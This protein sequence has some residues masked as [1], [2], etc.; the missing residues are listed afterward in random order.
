MCSIP[1]NCSVSPG[2]SNGNMGCPGLMATG[3]N[4]TNS[5]P[6]GINLD[7]EMVKADNLGTTFSQN[8]WASA[9][10]EGCLGC[11]NRYPQWPEPAVRPQLEIPIQATVGNDPNFGVNDAPYVQPL[12]FYPDNYPGTPNNPRGVPGNS[13]PVVM[14]EEK[15]MPSWPSI[16]AQEESVILL[17]AQQQQAQQQQAQ[18]QQAQQ[19]AQQRQMQAAEGQEPSDG[20]EMQD[21]DSNSVMML[22]RHIGNAIRGIIYDLSNWNTKHPEVPTEFWSHLQWVFGRDDRSKY[23]LYLILMS[24]VVYFFVWYI[25]LRKKSKKII[26]YKEAPVEQSYAFSAPRFSKPGFPLPPQSLPSSLKTTQ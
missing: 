1:P 16:D 23:I 8:A 25:M 11:P 24:I 21:A 14:R 7:Q 10:Q 26:Y 20:G 5:T 9:Q 19:Q 2:A 13:P 17:L 4:W 3:P 6:C 22:F 15:I 18:Q 12:S